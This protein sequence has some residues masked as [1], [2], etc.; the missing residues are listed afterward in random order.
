MQ[1]R[2]TYFKVFKFILVIG[3]IH[4]RERVRVCLC[5]CVLVCQGGVRE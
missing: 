5:V 2:V 1:H 3:G 4:V